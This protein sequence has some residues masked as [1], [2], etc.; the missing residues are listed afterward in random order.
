MK[1][2]IE[3]GLV[4]LVLCNSSF[5][6]EK[7][8]DQLI[9]DLGVQDKGNHTYNTACT[10]LMRKKGEAV[11]YLRKA[12]TDP[13]ER[14]RYYSVRTLGRINTRESREAL[15]TAFSDG[16][17][18]VREHA[19]YVLTWHPHTDAEEVYIDSLE[20]QDKWH[21]RD[22]IRALGKI[23][24]QKALPHLKSIRDNPEG[25]HFY[26]KALTAI[27]KIKA[28]ELPGEVSDALQ[29][30][31]KA[32][33]SRTVDERQLS[34]AETTIKGNIEIALPDIMNIYLW[35]LFKGNESKVEPNSKTILR[36]ASKLAYP[37]IRIG[38][39]DKDENVSRKVKGLITELGWELELK[40]DLQQDA[41]P[42]GEDAAQV[43]RGRSTLF[44]F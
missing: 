40:K 18:D 23:K 13:N 9:N 22:A 36:D 2:V 41:E 43:T 7:T 16:V 42:E 10:I 30:L 21:V 28:K 31:R 4:L 33:Y 11:P 39:K 27:R 3:I 34:A 1:K 5:A 44:T 32:K 20:S 37:Y 17:D 19:A 15:I 26:Y 38:L 25:W 29:I 24:S 35:R 8:M 6:E 12:L 14:I